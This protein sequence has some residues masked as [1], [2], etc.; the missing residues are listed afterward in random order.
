MGPSLRHTERGLL[1]T[2]TRGVGA[3]EEGCI[4]CS[5]VGGQLWEASQIWTSQKC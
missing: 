3:R 2:I 1:P 4:A 5:V